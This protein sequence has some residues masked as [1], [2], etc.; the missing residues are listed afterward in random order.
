MQASRSMRFRGRHAHLGKRSRNELLIHWERKADGYC[1]CKAFQRT[2]VIHQGLTVLHHFFLKDRRRIESELHPGSAAYP[3][4]GLRRED[5]G[6]TEQQAEPRHSQGH[7]R[8]VQR[9]SRS[10]AG[11]ES[12]NRCAGKG[13]Y[14]RVNWA[15]NWWPGRSIAGWWGCP[16]G[17]RCHRRFAASGRCR[18]SGRR[19]PANRRHCCS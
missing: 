1:A 2:T 8:C 16:P 10:H 11:G 4:H 9:A 14:G 18:P 5:Q 17:I 6:R 7:A 19:R 15:F 3:T 12:T 13:R